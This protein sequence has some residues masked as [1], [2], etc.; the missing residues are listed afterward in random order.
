MTHGTPLHEDQMTRLLER[1]MLPVTAD[2]ELVAGGLTRGRRATR[3]RRTAQAAGV[4]ATAVLATVAA[5]AVPSLLGGQVDQRPAPTSSAAD[6]A[7]TTASSPAPNPSTPAA[8]PLPPHLQRAQDLLLDALPDPVPRP[9]A[10]ARVD[11]DPDTRGV[12]ELVAIVTNDGSGAGIVGRQDAR[13]DRVVASPAPDDCVDTGDGW[14]FTSRS[15]PDVSGTAPGLAGSQ[16]IYILRTGN[17]VQLSAY[18]APEAALGG[19]P[20]RTDPV[21]DTDDLVRL[22]TTTEWFA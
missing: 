21:L 10:V 14:V 9:G 1:A 19:E 18:N 12:G 20:T 6:G 17:I 4:G 16:A 22:V 3:R 8:D 11:Y 7:T 2:D 13:C 5:V 15:T